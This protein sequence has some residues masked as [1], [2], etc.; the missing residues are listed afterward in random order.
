[1]RFN[2]ILSLL[3]KEF[4][5]IIRDRK[6]FLIMILLPLLIFP[7]LIGMM[8]IIMTTFTQVDDT[9]KFGVN[10]HVTDD[11]QHFVNKYSDDY[12]ITIIYDDVD[13]L[14]KMFDNDE[15]G[16]YV[17]NNGNNYELHYDESNS[18]FIA[19]SIIVENIY[20]DYRELY[21]ENT[22]NDLNVDY[23]LIKNSFNVTFVQES[24][25]E[26]GS[27]IPSVISMALIMIV[28]SVCFSV[29]IDVTTSEKEKGTLETLLSL[30]IKKSELITSKFITVFALSSMSG[31]LT[32]I[33]L[34]GTMYFAGNTL[35]MLGVSGL[36]IGF[37]SL[38][39]FLIAILLISL[40]FSGLLLSITIFS[41]NLKEAQNS[42]Y[43][44]ELFVTLISLLPMFG[45]NA[46]LKYALIPFVNIS[47]LF[48]NALAT[49]IDFIF[50]ILTFASTI[51]YSI[52]LIIIISK[53][54]N[55]ED[56]LFN[57]KNMLY[58]SFKNGKSKKVYF[59][60][61][62]SI[63]MAV[64]TY[65]LA[66]Y[67][68][69]I[70]INTS[71][72]FLVSIMPFT[73]ALVVLVSGTLVNFDF[74][75]GLKI[76]KF[77]FSKFCYSLMMYIAVYIIANFI[78]Q[79]VAII[80]PSVVKDYSVFES[81]LSFDNLLMSVL[82]VAVLPAISEEILFR[83]VIFNSFQKKFGSVIAI[84]CSALIFGIYHL[85]WLQSIFA[86]IL[87]LML[88]YTYIKTK[89]LVVPMILH[90]LNNLLA[91]LSSYY[92]IIYFSVSIPS[93]ITIVIF[94]FGLLIL[95]IYLFEIKDKE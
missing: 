68:S 1:M 4:L 40:L 87:G 20:K 25:T 47:L 94:A 76:N 66:M 70:F 79:F 52:L 74:K 63:F 91:V 80:F 10:Y 36:T 22:L 17:I 35:S 92:E 78:I 32:Y 21:I 44:L 15:I 43:P 13:S 34:F 48:N 85:N 57:T 54:Y 8:S 39:I 9:I 30:P 46:S 64:I 83:G 84:I 50:V 55:Q 45:V 31:I 7:L 73:I 95:S 58:L 60:V 77:E 69:L 27:L 49:N 14:K 37:K 19:S 26:M 29:A 53:L 12:E 38:L 90:F 62:A 75:K 86:F 2:V 18:S 88:A 28:S 56:I 51:I 11:F 3:K 93:L 67:F 65:L 82:V 71:K 41:K 23:Q 24:V 59:S 5:N 16:V 72:Y 61:L 6:S 33:S 81:F 89:S 42:L